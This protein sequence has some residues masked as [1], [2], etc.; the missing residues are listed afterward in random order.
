MPDKKKMMYALLLGCLGLSGCLT[1]DPTPP[2]RFFQLQPVVDKVA[3]KTWA[4]DGFIVIGPVELAPY[5]K[6]PQI[7]DRR[8]T[9]EL[10]YREMA[11]WAEALDKNIGW[12]L[13][14]N[15]AAFLGSDRVLPL[16]PAFSGTHD[17][18]VYVRIARFEGQPGGEA[19]LDAMFQLIA[20]GQTVPSGLDKVQLTCKVEGD[21]MQDV[22]KA[23]SLLLGQVSERIGRMI[24]DHKDHR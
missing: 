8:N 13:T 17:L 21:A 4:F 7:A 9:Y 16:T 1:P 23:Q 10:A 12:V 15:V 18:S 24:L 22:V 6:K 14:E 19:L 5:L 11:R 2:A 3:R 20:A